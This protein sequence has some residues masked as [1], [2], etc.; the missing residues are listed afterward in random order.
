MLDSSKPQSVRE[1]GPFLCMCL[2]ASAAL[3]QPL[4]TTQVLLCVQSYS[5]VL[6][7]NEEVACLESPL[8]TMG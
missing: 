4:A 6:F 3:S 1:R 7:L 8:P 5:N 2:L